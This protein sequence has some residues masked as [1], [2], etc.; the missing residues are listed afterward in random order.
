MLMR[1]LIENTLR[2]LYFTDHPVEFSR[3]NRDA[4]WYVS[5]E[6][7][8]EYI[9]NHHDFIKSEQRFDAISQLSSLYSRLSAGVHGRTVKDLEMK[10]ALERIKF[11]HNNAKEDIDYL[12]KCA[13]AVNFLLAIFHRHQVRSFSGI[14]QRLVFRGMPPEARRVWTDYDG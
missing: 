6:G 13:Q 7:L 8:F 4:K 10:T 5:V 1:G 9:R 12:N 3:M 2:H 11:D 14:D